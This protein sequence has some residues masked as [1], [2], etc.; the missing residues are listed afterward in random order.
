MIVEPLSCTSFV[1][2]PRLYSQISCTYAKRTKKQKLS[3]HLEALFTVPTPKFGPLKFWRCANGDCHFDGL[4][5][6]HSACQS[7]RHLWHN[8]KT[9]TGWILVSVCVNR[10]WRSVYTFWRPCPSP[11]KVSIVLMVTGRM[12]LELILPIKVTVTISTVLNFWRWRRRNV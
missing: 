3:S 8:V 12:S 7:A 9:L 11:S 6:I 5:G 4:N 1:R 2:S 10:A